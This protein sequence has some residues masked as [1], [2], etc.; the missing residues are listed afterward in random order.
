VLTNKGKRS[1]F[2]RRTFKVFPLVN[3]KPRFFVIGVGN[4]RTP[5]IGAGPATLE[6][7]CVKTHRRKLLTLARAFLV[8]GARKSLMNA[9]PLEWTSPYVASQEPT[10]LRVDTMYG[11]ICNKA[12]GDTLQLKRTG[13]VGDGTMWALEF[14]GIFDHFTTRSGQRDLCGLLSTTREETGPFAWAEN[15]ALQGLSVTMPEVKTEMELLGETIRSSQALRLKFTETKKR[16]NN[17]MASERMASPADCERSRRRIAFFRLDE[18][19][20]Q[21]QQQHQQSMLD[22]SYGNRSDS[23]S[24]SSSNKGS[25]SP[26][27]TEGIVSMVTVPFDLSD[28]GAGTQAITLPVQATTAQVWHSA[29]TFCERHGLDG[30]LCVDVAEAILLEQHNTKNAGLQALSTLMTEQTRAGAKER[31][32][33]DIFKQENDRLDPLYD[34][35]VEQEAE[36]I[37]DDDERQLF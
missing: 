14:T 35:L 37:P 33:G 24:S 10:G 12:N 27:T 25:S 16:V 13:N 17:K 23:N 22:S 20:E 5:I 4:C 21:R 30:E 11:T 3:G 6:V 8:P 15:N 9:H 18:K 26:D 2:N 1:V 31:E 19:Q 7:L 28:Q 36:L 34:I 32:A 29:F